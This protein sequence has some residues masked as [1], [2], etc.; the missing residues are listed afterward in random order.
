MQDLSVIEKVNILG[1]ELNIYGNTE[2]PLFLAKDIA[3][4]IGHSNITKMLEIVGNKDELTSGYVVDTIGRKQEMKLLT[5]NQVYK[6]LMR[7]DKPVAMEIQEGLYNFLKAWRKKEISVIPVKQKLLLNIIEAD[8]EMNRAIAINDYEV[9][10]VK[11]LEI[12]N[13]Q[14]KDYINHVVI[15][16]KYYITATQIGNKFNMSAVR[17]N[18]VLNN[19]GVI[20]KKGNKWYLTSDYYGIGDYR[21]FQK[22]NGEWE[23]GTSLCYSNDG[24]KTLFNILI[25]HGYEPANAA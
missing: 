20:Y 19:L 2:N 14:Q 1:L 22:P 4:A 8:T 18:K 3:K 25:A 23:K 7:S 11:P 10:Y 12:E 13:K 6:V 21:Y 17:L 15:N 9:K 24:E 16:E 5:E